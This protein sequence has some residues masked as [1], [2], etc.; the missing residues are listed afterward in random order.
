MAVSDSFKCVSVFILDHKYGDKKQPIE[1]VFKGK[2]RA[3]TLEITDICWDSFSKQKPPSLYSI[4]KDMFLVEYDVGN[5]RE[6]R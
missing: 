6:E 5:E 1:W 3:H 2:M 4:G